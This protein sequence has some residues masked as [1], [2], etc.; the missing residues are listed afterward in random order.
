MGDENIAGFNTIDSKAF[1]YFG[2]YHNVGNGLEQYVNTVIA[3][4]PEVI[5]L[6]YGLYDTTYDNIDLFIRDYVNLINQLKENLPNTKLYM[7]RVFPG[8][9]EAE[10]LTT[11][12]KLMIENTPEINSAIT[13]VSG[14][15]FTDV[16]D[17]EEFFDFGY[18]C[19]L[20]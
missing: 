3:D 12:G 8:D 13:R 2:T 9:P 16:I 6:N 11:V 7:C 5:I 15:T 19:P 1:L 18:Y 17:P 10:E 14:E 4:E 20:R